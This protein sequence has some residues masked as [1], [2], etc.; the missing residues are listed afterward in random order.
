[1]RENA[2]RRAKGEPSPPTGTADLAAHE[3]ADRVGHGP[4]HRYEELSD[5]LVEANRRARAR[6]ADGDEDR[7]GT[8]LSARQHHLPEG[9][10]EAFAGRARPE[11]VAARRGRKAK[12]TVGD[13]SQ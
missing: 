12:K 1:M 7:T 8:D 2:E 9:M 13:E 11:D 4:G 3:L 6:P 5:E 10:H